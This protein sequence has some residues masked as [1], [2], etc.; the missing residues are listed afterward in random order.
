MFELLFLLGFP[1]LLASGASYLTWRALS[2]PVV[3]LIV[4][5]VVLYLLYAALM[6]LLD[7]GPVGYSLSIS[8]PG[9]APVS[10]PWFPFLEPYKIPLVAFAVA[11]IPLL[12]VL[13]RVFKKGRA[14]E[15]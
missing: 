7:P 5:T 15:V 13:L 9:Q 11:A 2:R 12:T 8:E 1:L 4:A 10:E 6:W 14:S 3:F